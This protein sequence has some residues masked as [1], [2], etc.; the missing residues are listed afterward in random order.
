MMDLATFCFPTTILFGAGALKRLPGELERL[1]IR[2]P[3]LVTDSGLVRTPV[4]QRAAALFPG[5]A[6]FSAV[7]PNPTERSVLD[8]VD[9]FRRQGCDGLVGVGGGSPLDAAKAMRLMIT[10]PLPLAEYDDLRDGGSR[11]TSDLPPYVAIATTA[12]TGSEVSRSAV[13]TIEQTQRKTVIFS[14]HLIPTLALADPELTAS[15]PPR[16]LPAPAWT[17][18]RTTSRPICRRDTI[19]SATRWLW[20]GPDLFGRTCRA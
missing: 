2:K 7:E 13:I 16:S 11:I 20:P 12:G 14:P 18:S 17:P 5:A 9:C 1:G 10:H 4:F 3:L 19:P 15:L 8:G 6:V